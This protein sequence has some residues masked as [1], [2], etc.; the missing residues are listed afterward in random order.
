MKRAVKLIASVLVTVLFLWWAFRDTDWDT[1]LASLKSANYLWL[2]PYFVCL[3]C[4]HVAR[5]L[6][7]GCLLSGLERVPFRKL[8]EASGIGFMMLLVLPFRLGEFARPFLIAQR[9][10]IRRSAAMTS[11]VLERIVDGLFVAASMRVLLFFVP[12][13]TAEVRYVKLG[14]W[15]MFAVFGG[16]LVFL[17]FGLWQ[18]ARTVRLVRSTVG[19]FAPALADKVADIVDTFVGAMRQLPDGRQVALFFLY[20]VVY[21][22]VNGFGMMI[23][24][25][26]F[27]C[28][29][30]A[31]GAACQPMS[32]TLFQAYVVL[33]VLVVGVM[34]PAAPGMMGTFQ[35]A[36]KVGLSLFLPAAVVN[37]GGLAYA[38]VLWFAQTA[39]QILFGLV[40]MSLGHMSFRDIAGKL[41]KE[42]EAAAPTA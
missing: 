38:N 27:D 11:V 3:T 5:T 36:C 26:A 17:L 13:E 19:R 22:G 25:N 31:T 2:I 20:T 10:S 41:D 39:Q 24:A 14:S 34:I 33:C 35:A 37:A 29:S 8:N 12:N 30:A 21:W 7:W 42:G 32:L 4:I 16:G 1:Q 23:L 18:Q 28:S 40:L 15:L 6:R 9:S